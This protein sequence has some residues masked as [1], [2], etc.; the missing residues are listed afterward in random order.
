MNWKK[1]FYY[2]IMGV[3][4]FGIISLIVLSIMGGVQAGDLS[5]TG[6]PIWI[7]NNIDKLYFYLGCF[8]LA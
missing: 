7:W 4:Y 6:L 1:S 5:W 8:T 2:L 3:I